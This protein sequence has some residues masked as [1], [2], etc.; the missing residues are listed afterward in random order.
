M[1]L[2][3]GQPGQAADH[4]QALTGGRRT[5]PTSTSSRRLPQPEPGKAPLNEASEAVQTIG[6]S[7]DGHQLSAAVSQC[8]WILKQPLFVFYSRSPGP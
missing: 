2:P 8:D 7:S 1:R 6:T 5:R 3:V 4:I